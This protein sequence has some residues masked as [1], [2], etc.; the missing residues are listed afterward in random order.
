MAES[1]PVCGNSYFES[2]RLKNYYINGRILASFV[3]TL[4]FTPLL[5]LLAYSFILA[6]RT[7]VS[8][9]ICQS[10]ALQLFVKLGILL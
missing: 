2:I 9:Y 5:R 8:P 3:V 7:H 1:W 4:V 6:Y 10:I